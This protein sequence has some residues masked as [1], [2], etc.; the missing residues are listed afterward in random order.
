M[1]IKATNTIRLVKKY[2][3]FIVLG[4][5]VIFLYRYREEFLSIEIVEP[6]YIFPVLILSFLSIFLNG[7]F[8]KFFFQLYGANLRF[9]EWFGL[10]VINTFGN[11]VTP[12]R[13]GAISN[14]IYL[15]KK[16]QLAYSDFV[17]SLAASYI[18]VFLVNS[19]FG[20][21]VFTLSPHYLSKT[22]SVI[23]NSFFGSI[24]LGCL[25]VTLFAPKFPDSRYRLFKVVFNVLNAWR[26]LRENFRILLA[27]SGVNIGNALLL[28]GMNYFLFR[29]IGLEISLASALA[30]GIFSS[31][32]AL[33]SITPG[34]LGVREA[35]AA[36]GAVGFNIPVASA[37]TVS[38]VER[39]AVFCLCL[40]FGMIFSHILMKKAMDH[41]T[42]EE[43]TA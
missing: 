11:L 23:L 4:L 19:G 5:A 6:L 8:N 10:S 1:G 16:H 3:T 30:M 31:F 38:F 34:N 24:F 26:K 13:G 42:K 36:L 33:V 27:I 2:L 20:W 29:T 18:N 21:A 22:Q 35:F 7:V 37:V 40:V 12:L 39:I 15:K 17:G 9:N 43:V 25:F 32:S 28:A 41:E 14:A